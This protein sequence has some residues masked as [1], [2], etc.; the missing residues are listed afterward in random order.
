MNHAGMNDE[1]YALYVLGALDAE[2]SEQLEEHLRQQCAYCSEK[3]N[4]AMRLS[5]AM[6]GIA[7]Q[8]QPPVSLRKRVLATVIPAP[9]RQSGLL[10]ALAALAAACIGLVVFS[11]WSGAQNRSLLNQLVQARL[12]RNQ[13]RSALEL[14][15]RSE[16]RAVQFGNVPNAPRGR[17][18]VSRS[19]GVVFIGT[20]LPTLPRNKTF[21]LWLV[22]ATGPPG[23]AGTFRADSSGNAVNVAPAN[24]SASGAKAVAVSVEPA[25]GS[26]APTTKPFLIVPLA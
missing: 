12:E 5:A 16:T 21:E 4:E 14:M 26:N 19:G 15:S 6:A 23:A 18:F 3:V 13:L 2:Q 11:I 7:E 17:V 1:N 24:V 20:G 22:P 9:R 8:A 10:Y 25:A